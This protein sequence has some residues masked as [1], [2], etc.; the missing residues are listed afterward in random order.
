MLGTDP[1]PREG[2]AGDGGLRDR[3]RQEVG[4]GSYG[5]IGEDVLPGVLPVPVIVEVDPGVKEA[6]SRRLDVH[7][8]REP[9][10]KN[11]IRKSDAI[12]VISGVEVIPF[13]S[14][15]PL[16]V[17]FDV[18]GNPQHRAAG[19]ERVGS[20]ILTGVRGVGRRC[21]TIVCPY[22]LKR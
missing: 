9:D 8:R 14:G 18:D 6:V 1:E 2:G 20:T 11:G 3:E 16:T 13:S 5:F 7:A 22:D 12:L 15:V 4:S 19:H 21:V 10:R 17:I